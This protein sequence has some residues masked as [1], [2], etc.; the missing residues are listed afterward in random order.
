MLT[1]SPGIVSEG[2]WGIDVFFFFLLV[3]DKIQAQFLKSSILY[4]QFLK[5]WTTFSL[6]KVPSNIGSSMHGLPSS[7]TVVH[8]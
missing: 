3:Y 8:R 2:N 6:Q 7:V 1:N 4:P 5:Y